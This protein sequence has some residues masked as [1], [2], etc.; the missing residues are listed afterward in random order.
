M[1]LANLRSSILFLLTVNIFAICQPIWGTDCSRVTGKAGDGQV[2]QVDFGN[3]RGDQNSPEVL[4]SGME[5]YFTPDVVPLEIPTLNLDNDGDREDLTEETK[6]FIN[7]MISLIHQKSPKLSRETFSQ[8]DTWQF[9]RVYKIL[10]DFLDYLARPKNGYSGLPYETVYEEF[11][12]LEEVLKDYQFFEK[13]EGLGYTLVPRPDQLVKSYLPENYENKSGALSSRLRLVSMDLGLLSQI[14]Q[15]YTNSLARRLTNGAHRKQMFSLMTEYLADLNAYLRELR[16]ELSILTTD[17]KVVVDLIIETEQVLS[18]P[19][20][21]RAIG[22]GGQSPFSSTRQIVEVLNQEIQQ[23]EILSLFI[24]SPD[25]PLLQDT[26]VVAEIQLD[27][28]DVSKLRSDLEYAISDRSPQTGGDYVIHWQQAISQFLENINSSADISLS[29]EAQSELLMLMNWVGENIDDI[30]RTYNPFTSTWS[31]DV[32][33][34]SNQLRE[35]VPKL[36]S[37]F[38]E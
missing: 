16:S 1:K 18:L 24:K 20:F 28:S 31:H 25:Q 4:G 5:I 13:L 2:I 37:L 30:P 12:K 17:M 38:E 26:T 33:I 10:P 3:S 9:H 23:F 35:D 14:D 22:F 27:D 32:V 29:S 6:Q 7:Y 15:L 8:N 21:Q 34:A 36:V 11:Q 19:V